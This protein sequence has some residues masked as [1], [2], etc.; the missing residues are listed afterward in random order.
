M[1]MRAVHHLLCLPGL[2]CGIALAQALPD[3]GP[4]PGHSQQRSERIRL[5]DAGSRI[6]E[7]RVG[8]Q[9]RIISVQPKIGPMPG[10]EVQSPDGA[11]RRAG[12]QSGAETATAPRVWNILK[13]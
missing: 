9:T 3:S 10:Y 11:L 13:F 7:L 1:P 4:P 12:S 8:G 5:E 6:D 2:A